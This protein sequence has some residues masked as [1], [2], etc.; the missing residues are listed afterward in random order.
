MGSVSPRSG[1]RRSRTARWWFGAMPMQAPLPPIG[2]MRAIGRQ[3]AQLG[4]ELELEVYRLADDV[5]RVRRLEPSKMVPQRLA[6]LTGA[7]A[8]HRAG[9]R[10]G[11]RTCAVAAPRTFPVSLCGLPSTVTFGALAAPTP[12][13]V[14]TPPRGV[15]G[16]SSAAPCQSADL[17]AGWPLPPISAI[18]HGQHGR[19]AAAP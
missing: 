4:G 17:S 9:R 2:L 5:E 19:P 3:Q 11:R 15:R 6:V 10:G 18:S 7:Q 13:P 14:A 1:A 8:T 12:P 16:R